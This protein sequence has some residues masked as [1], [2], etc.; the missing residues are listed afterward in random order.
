[1]FRHPEYFFGF[2]LLLPLGILLWMS[3]LRGRRDL[4]TLLGHWRKGAYLDIFTV[5]WFFSSLAIL[6]FSVFVILAL[7]DPE[8]RGSPEIRALESRDVVFALDIS[9]SMLARDASPTRLERS[10]EVMRGIL[11]SRGGTGR[12]ALVVFRGIGTKIIPI[13]EDLALFETVFQGIGPGVVSRQGSDLASGLEAA[14]EAFPRGVES[15]RLLFVFTDGESFGRQAGAA[16][17]L[18]GERDIRIFPVAAGTVEGATIP[19]AEGEVLLDSEGEPVRTRLNPDNL[20][21]LAAETD[22]EYLSL[23][24]PA[25]MRKIDALFGS[26][27]VQYNEARES[28]YR[29]FLAAALGSLCLYFLI[30]V[31]RWKDTF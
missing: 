18:A 30:R 16:A 20:R 25:L 3:F 29:S 8:L 2:L 28:A 6:L 15:E 21:I 10:V 31:V 1:M 19:L 27:S 14:L 5:K 13:T 12:F 17:A 11:A 7:A 24:D 9:L 22:G 23:N 4:K 26:S